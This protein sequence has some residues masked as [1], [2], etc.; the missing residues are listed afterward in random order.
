M[1]FGSAF[2]C[3]ACCDSIL[4]CPSLQLLCRYSKVSAAD[5]GAQG[6][7]TFQN[8]P[9]ES[10]QTLAVEPYPEEP[11]LEN[12]NPDNPDQGFAVLDHSHPEKRIWVSRRQVFCLR[13]YGTA[14][15]Q[16]A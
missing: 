9:V 10:E 6:F 12:P 4:A 1:F 11:D 2:V 3:F 13:R 8:E 15:I 14:L 16:S 5:S 7:K